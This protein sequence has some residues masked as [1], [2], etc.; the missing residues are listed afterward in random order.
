MWQYQKTDELYHYGVLGMKWGHRKFH[1]IQSI[2]NKRQQR[3]KKQEETRK[4]KLLE[5]ERDLKNKVES[6]RR[7][8]ANRIKFYGGKNTALN[9]I[10]EEASYNRKQNALKMITTNVISAGVAGVG[11]TIAIAGSMPVLMLATLPTAVGVSAYNSVKYMQIDSKITNHAREQ[12][13][14]TKDS[15]YGHDVVTRTVKK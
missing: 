10:K 12:E 9:A 3:M 13:A 15:E 14:Y 8:A 4:R 5:S 11:T 2:R 6:N 1:P 7:E